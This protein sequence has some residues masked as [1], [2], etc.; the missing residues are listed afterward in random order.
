MR[1]LVVDDNTADAKGL[2]EML[3]EKGF[4][5]HTVSSG[6]DAIGALASKTWEPEVMILDYLMPGL[7][8]GDVLDAMRVLREL[9]QIPVI[10]LTA[11][12]VPEKVRQHADLVLKKPLD[13]F[14]LVEAIQAARRSLP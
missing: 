6:V 5:V 1:V 13:L 14:K 9:H 7:D 8:G 11:H 3:G 4:D 10:V 2:A 12:D